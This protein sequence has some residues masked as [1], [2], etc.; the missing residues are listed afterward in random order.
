MFFRKNKVKKY[1]Y[2]LFKMM[3][4][5]RKAGKSSVNSANRLAKEIGE[6]P[7]YQGNI[8]SHTLKAMQRSLEE[9]LRSFKK[10]L[11]H[12]EEA[13]KNASSIDERLA[14][15][16]RSKKTIDDFLDEIGGN[17]YYEKVTAEFNKLV[18]GFNEAIKIRVEKYG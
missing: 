15:L 7:N 3:I 2:H 10:A 11:L 1:E 12:A 13:S 8:S 18:T 6:Q 16:I 9:S 14:I 4:E 5:I 17:F